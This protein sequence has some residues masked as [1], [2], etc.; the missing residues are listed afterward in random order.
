LSLSEQLHI[1]G[2]VPDTTF[3][4]TSTWRGPTLYYHMK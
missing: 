3:K 4:F 2:I 1:E